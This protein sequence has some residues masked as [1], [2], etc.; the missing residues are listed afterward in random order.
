MNTFANIPIFENRLGNSAQLHSQRQ[1][2][3]NTYGLVIQEEDVAKRKPATKKQWDILTKILTQASPQDLVS[4]IL[5]DAIYEGEVNVEL[6]RQ[7]PV[8]ADLLYSIKWMEK[9]GILHVEFQRK[10]DENMAKR[11]WEYNHLASSHTGLPVYS[12]VIYLLPDSPIVDPYYEVN[13]PTGFTVHQFHFQNIKLWELTAEALKEQNLPGLLP[14]LPLT[15]DGKRPE[16]VEGMIESLRQ[17]GRE[18]LLPLG[19]AFSARVFKQKKAQQ[20]LKERFDHMRDIFEDSWAYQEMVQEG[21]AK[22]LKQGLKQGLA[23]G[24]EQGLKQGLEQGKQQGL[25]QGKQQGLEQG[26]QQGLEQGKQQ[27]LEQIVVRFVELHF[28]DLVPLAK[29]QAALATTSQQLQEI[30]DRL[31]VAHTDDEA[32]AILGQQ[33]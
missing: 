3:L 4:W 26:K 30:L 21:V 19:Y 15:K 14:L 25:E 16:V 23:S 33:K 20:W 1:D 28:P 2:H 6:Q 22:G 17:A 29:Q 5:N 9:E 13:F 27:G 12:V 32:R 18:D 10:R 7:H 11:V 8:F 24:L 31:F